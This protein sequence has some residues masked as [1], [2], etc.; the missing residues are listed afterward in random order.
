[1]LEALTEATESTNQNALTIK[2]NINQK[3]ENSLLEKM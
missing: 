3:M 1:M 2:K